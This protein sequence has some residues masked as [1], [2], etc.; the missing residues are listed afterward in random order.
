MPRR[1]TAR[2]YETGVHGILNG[3]NNIYRVPISAIGN[4]RGTG[5]DEGH[6][7]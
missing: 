6:Q 4:L 2:D 7:Q 1:L 5:L 3:W